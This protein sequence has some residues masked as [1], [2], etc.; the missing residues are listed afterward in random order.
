MDKRLRY[1]LLFF[2]VLSVNTRLVGQDASSVDVS[3]MDNVQMKA[4]FD[5]ILSKD[6]GEKAEETNA[7][8]YAA[9]ASGEAAGETVLTILPWTQAFAS[10][11]QDAIKIALAASIGATATLITK[12]SLEEARDLKK[13]TEKHQNIHKANKT[14][15]KTCDEIYEVYQTLLMYYEEISEAINGYKEFKRFVEVELPELVGSIEHLSIV[16]TSLYDLDDYFD[17]LDRQFY[18]KK[19]E[20]YIQRSNK[21]AELAKEVFLTPYKEGGFRA[22]D[23]WRMHQ[24]ALL[25]LEVRDLRRSVLYDIRQIQHLI[26]N[27]RRRGALL[28]IKSS[29]FDYNTY[30]Y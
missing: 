2:I 25:H 23:S 14:I 24:L 26:F 20:L 1:I 30:A 21:I 27:S 22:S 16:L 9:M 3:S 17:L 11:G 28:T 6:N 8:L 12:Y 10:K 7:A 18:F 4:Y 19:Y 15:T 29:F 5:D 13:E